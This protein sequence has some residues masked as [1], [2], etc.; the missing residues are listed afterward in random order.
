MTKKYCPDETPVRV[1]LRKMIVKEEEEEEEEECTEADESKDGA[2][3]EM[4]KN[5][6]EGELN[7]E[8]KIE[9]SKIVEKNSAEAEEGLNDEREV[10]NVK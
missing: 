4:Q 7:N 8:R 9:I 2:E 5:T 10:M 3:E 1:G 6:A